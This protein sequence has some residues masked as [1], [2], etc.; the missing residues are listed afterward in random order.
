LKL[1]DYKQAPNCRRVRIF[2]AEKGIDVPR[3]TVDLRAGAH[4]LP[5][6]LS[7]NPHGVV[8]MLELDD[9]TRIGESMAICR[10][11]EELQPEPALFGTDIRERAI[12]E[13]W[14]R[15]I[16]IEGFLAVADVFRNSVPAFRD[17]GLP[18]TNDPVEQIPALIERGT[19]A[20]ARFLRRLDARLSENEYLVGERFTVADITALV[21]VDF[22]K[23]ARLSVPSDCENVL[24]WHSLVAARPS[25]QE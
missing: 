14:N 17:K 13:M 2:L 3:E 23:W 5:E 18:G 25:A 9:G 4:L 20:A 10:Y 11:F 12:V 7:I 15:R 24:R 19:Q 8:P 22:A 21:T 16:E 6:F 1:Y